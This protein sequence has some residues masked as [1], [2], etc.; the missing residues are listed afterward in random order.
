MTEGSAQSTRNKA[1][2][3]KLF[4]SK[5]GIENSLTNSILE[6]K[7]MSI[8]KLQGLRVKVSSLDEWLSCD[9]REDVIGA[10][11]QGASKV[12]DYIIIATSSEGTVRNGPGDTIKLELMKI[13]KGEYINPH[14]SIFYYKLDDISEVSNPAMWPKCNPNIGK[15]VTYE[16]YQLDVES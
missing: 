12:D 15:T 4:S 3:P 7:P 14:V 16:T 13:L 2:R 10:I 8:D 1:I 5:K 6:I 11:E 9:I